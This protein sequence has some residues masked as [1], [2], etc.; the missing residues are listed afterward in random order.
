[1]NRIFCSLG[2]TAILLVLAPV[3]SGAQDS[4]TPN[5][6]EQ[7]DPDFCGA[8]GAGCDPTDVQQWK[9]IGNRLADLSSA[10][11]SQYAYACAK[12]ADWKKEC[13]TDPVA[14]LKRLGIE[15]Y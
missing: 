10:D 8:G 7:L 1:M 14:V 11:L 12:H 6:T 4:A 3:A 13:E 15:G 9:A 5:L 2:V